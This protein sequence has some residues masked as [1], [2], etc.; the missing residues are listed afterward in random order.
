MRNNSWLYLILVW[1]DLFLRVDPETTSCQDEP[2][3]IVFYSMLLAIFSLFCFKCKS[4]KPSVT[5]KQHGTMVIVYQHCFY[6]GENAFVWR[7]QPLLLGKYPAGNI[8]LS[9]AILMAGASVSKI[10]LVFKHMKLC[11][12][13]IRSYFI[14]Q[15]KLLFPV[16]L[17]YWESY[18]STLLNQVKDMKNVVWSGDGRYDSMGHSAKFGVYTVFCC[19]L[20]K[21]VHF[22]LL[23][24]SFG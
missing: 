16:V 23:Q 18:R 14:H 3:F 5:M 21:I 15:D 12:Y 9:F 13:N 1:F 4:N 20:M 8:L 2:K 17:S 11:M 19:T 7:S 6:C 10:F 22:E 24:V